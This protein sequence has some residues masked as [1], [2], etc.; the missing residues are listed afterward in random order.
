MKIRYEKNLDEIV[1]KSVQEKLLT[2]NIAVIG[3]G[4]QGGY[5]LEFL[6][7]LGINSIT[8]WDGDNFSESNLNRQIGC[9]EKTLGQNKAEVMYLRMKEIDSS[10]QLYCKPWFFGDK[11]TDL[12][13]LLKTDIIFLAGDCYYNII[14]MRQLIRQAILDGIPAIDCPAN[15][16][17]GYIYIE[18]NND[19]G[20]YDYQTINEIKQ[21]QELNNNEYGSQT[22]YKCALVAAEAVNQMV[23]YFANS[24][25]ANIDS[26]LNIDIYH[27]QYSQF[28]KY[29]KF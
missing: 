3:C 20:H 16:L 11:E 9:T 14:K 18:T 17:G 28:D 24:R 10:L 19:L 8:F 12:E 7:R 15:L 27:H 21:S 29:G 4:G 25:Y 22:A 13:D 26:G 6:A 23:L 5:I 2:K 1:T